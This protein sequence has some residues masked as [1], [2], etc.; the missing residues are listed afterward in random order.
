MMCALT[1]RYDLRRVTK[2]EFWHEPDG[3]ST[4]LPGHE[5]AHP[6][7]LTMRCFRN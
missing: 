2:V 1:K 3:S 4:T 7:R 5:L 6:F